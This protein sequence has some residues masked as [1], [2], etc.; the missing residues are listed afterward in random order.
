MIKYK[1]V[2]LA[3]ALLGGFTGTARADRVVL[4]P[5]GMTIAPN[6]IKAEFNTTFSG[7]DQNQGWL[8]Y[9]MPIGLEVQTQF[10]NIANKNRSLSA[11]DL[12]YPFLSEFGPA[13][14]V[15]VGVRDILGTGNEHRSFY[16]AASKT[17]PLSDGQLKIAHNFRI[18]A[19][20]GTERMDGLFIGV[21]SHL[22]AGL[23]FDAEFY[24]RR[25]NVSLAL[26]LVRNMQARAYSLDGSIFYGLSY[27]LIR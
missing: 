15:S 16:V 19:G 24:R 22:K 18:S 1:T 4:G 14:A 20:Y 6:S 5:D 3:T 8:Q 26:P 11:V 17:L 12:Q 9:A 25:P 27:S 2:L 23:F 7:R 13:P 21:H 10:F